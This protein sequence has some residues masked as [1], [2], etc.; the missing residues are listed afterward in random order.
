MTYALSGKVAT[1]TIGSQV[2]DP[3][4]DDPAVSGTMTAATDWRLNFGSPPEAYFAI[5]GNGFQETVATAFR[6]EGSINVVVE[7][8]NATVS[9]GNGSWAPTFKSGQLVYLELIAND[10]AA[11]DGGGGNVGASLAAYGNARL[12][13]FDYSPNRDGSVQKFS[14][15]FMTH[16]PWYG[17]LFGA[18]TPAQTEPVGTQA[19]DPDGL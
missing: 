8:R 14:I 13:Q 10:Y 4:A 2:D 6:G 17:S 11:V 18:L 1:I 7:N 5:G 12:G 3:S 15:P 16:G 9:D 19:A